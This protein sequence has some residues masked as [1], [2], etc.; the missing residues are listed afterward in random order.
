M[1]SYRIKYLKIG[2]ELTLF[3]RK[4]EFWE[5]FENWNFESYLKMGVLEIKFENWN[6]KNYLKKEFF[7]N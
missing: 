2:V 5:L 4:L 1:K 7:E 3:E 6:L